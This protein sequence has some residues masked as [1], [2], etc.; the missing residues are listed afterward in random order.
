M[1]NSAILSKVIFP[2]CLHPG[3]I[4]RNRARD[5][6]LGQA[7]YGALLINAIDNKKDG[8]KSN[9]CPRSKIPE[10]RGQNLNFKH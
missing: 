6:K 9:S 10:T 5:G 4:L 7:K 2:L 1:C 8:P 3:I